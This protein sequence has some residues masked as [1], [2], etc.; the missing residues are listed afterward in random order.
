MARL[1]RFPALENN[2]ANFLTWESSSSALLRTRPPARETPRRDGADS[3][4][5]NPQAFASFPNR[6]AMASAGS[7]GTAARWTF[8]GM[9]TAGTARNFLP[10][11]WGR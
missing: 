2:R 9:L 6:F 10:A 7:T 5:K 3:G 1:Y 4:A 11:N 8:F